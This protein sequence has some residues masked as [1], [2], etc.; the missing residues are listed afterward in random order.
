MDWF[1]IIYKGCGHFFNMLPSQELSQEPF[2]H[3]EPL[4]SRLY[5]TMHIVL[6]NGHRLQRTLQFDG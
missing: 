1:T 4:M 6:N 5:E 2:G 3:V